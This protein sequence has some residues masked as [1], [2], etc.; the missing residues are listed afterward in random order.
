MYDPTQTLLTEISSYLDRTGMPLTIF[1]LKA[2]NDPN[3]I[4]NLRAGREPRVKTI[5]R[6]MDFIASHPEEP[7]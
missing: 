7:S 3:L 2:I 6:V 4:K 1:G 5:K